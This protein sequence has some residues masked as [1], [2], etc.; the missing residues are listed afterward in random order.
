MEQEYIKNVTRYPAIHPSNSNNLRHQSVCAGGNRGVSH[1]QWGRGPL[2]PHQSIGAKNRTFSLFVDF[3]P[4]DTTN[5]ALR[6]I[7]EVEGR[8]NDVFISRKAR[9]FRREAFGFVRFY[10]RQDARNAVRNLD[11][12]VMKGMRLSVSMAKY[13]KRGGSFRDLNPPSEGKTAA[14]RKINNPAFRDQRKY[15]EV[16]MG[17]QKGTSK[18]NV[19]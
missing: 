12:F 19:E 11:G 1:P 6:K 18:V 15:A 7:F 17:K 2:E 14:F 3:I 13:N 5:N 4:I 10:N 16:L 9:K 8:V